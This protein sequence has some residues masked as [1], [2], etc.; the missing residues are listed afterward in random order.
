VVLVV[1]VVNNADDSKS[2]GSNY[3]DDGSV[4]EIHNFMSMIR[5]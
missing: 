5:L 4:I 1:P 3:S 2:Q